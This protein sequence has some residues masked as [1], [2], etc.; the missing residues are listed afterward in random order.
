[1]PY[2]DLH[3]SPGIADPYKDNQHESGDV[4][5]HSQLVF[6]S[7]RKPCCKGLYQKGETATSGLPSEAIIATARLTAYTIFK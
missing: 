5:T 2:T 3:P 7:Y 6:F 1:L 4:I